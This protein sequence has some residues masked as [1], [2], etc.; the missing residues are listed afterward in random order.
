MKLSK[1]DSSVS[2]VLSSPNSHIDLFGRRLAFL[3]PHENHCVSRETGVVEHHLSYDRPEIYFYLVGSDHLGIQII[4]K[5][6]K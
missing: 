1:V 6:Q 2:S 3:F 5:E 4:Y